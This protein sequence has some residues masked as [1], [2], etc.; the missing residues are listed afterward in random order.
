[1]KIKSSWLQEMRG[2]L[3][4]PFLGDMSCFRTDKWGNIVGLRKPIPSKIHVGKQPAYQHQLAFI[5]RYWRILTPSQ[6]ADYT[7]LGALEDITGYD[8]FIRERYPIGELNFLPVGDMY[9]LT[10]PWW[11]IDYRPRWLETYDTVS[12]MGRVLLEFFT[13][14]LLSLGAVTKAEVFIWYYADVCKW[15]ASHLIKVYRILSGW[16]EATVW[17]DTQPSYSGT[18]TTEFTVQADE[19]WYSF[20]VTTDI[21]NFIASGTKFYGWMI[22]GPRPT[23]DDEFCMI[24][25]SKE[26]FYSNMWPFLKITL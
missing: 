22:E 5:A 19:T 1:M 6:K 12:E 23:G 8:Y 25:R 13:E 4:R 21:N 17:W 24:W 16:D 20:D 7:A 10:L 18:P 2:S 9:I 15:Q 3:G 26:T 14:P 11:M